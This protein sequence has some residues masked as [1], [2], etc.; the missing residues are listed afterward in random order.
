MAE[1]K[2]LHEYLIVISREGELEVVP[3]GNEYAIKEIEAYFNRVSEQWSDAYL[4][5][6]IRGPIEI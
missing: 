4:C 6:V 5:K 1:K 3:F 2:L